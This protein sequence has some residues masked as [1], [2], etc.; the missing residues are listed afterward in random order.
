MPPLMD[1]Y[2]SYLEP[3]NYG[4]GYPGSYN[5]HGMFH[6]EQAQAQHPQP[7]VHE[8][9]TFDESAFEDA[10]AQASQHADYMDETVTL[11]HID[12][13]ISAKEA[14]DMYWASLQDSAWKHQN[15]MHR[16]ELDWQKIPTLQSDRSNSLQ[17]RIGSDAIPY[18]EQ[19]DRRPDQDLL[20]RDELARTAG[21]LLN[22]VQHDTSDKFQGSQFLAF[23]RKIRDK[24]VEVRDEAF[25]E[26]GTTNES[27]SGGQILQPYQRQ[28]LE[29]EESQ[30]MTNSSHMD[31]KIGYAE[32]L[33]AAAAQAQAHALHPGGPFYPGQS[34]TFQPATM[35][36]GISAADMV[37]FDRPD[38]SGNLAK[39]YQKPFVED[40]PIAPGSSSSA[41]VGA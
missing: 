25:R 29:G 12:H 36:G 23:M 39:R 19:K 17:I 7:Q 5:D 13:D 20:D 15:A 4:R 11:E 6:G 34:P 31:Y 18:T 14:E 26:R 9:P 3:I 35:S 30:P 21:Q 41:R 28:L 37:H 16:D 8:D 22:S 32:G 27:D 24:E 1:N 10:F 40:A 2:G 33:A 38:E